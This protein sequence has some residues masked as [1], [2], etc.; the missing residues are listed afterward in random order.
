MDELNI[1]YCLPEIGEEE[2]AEVVDT[3]RSGW[4]T[5]GPKT[6]AFEE[7]I[8]AYT[9]AKYAVAVNSCTAALH[10]SLL[11]Y[12]IGRGDEVIT[13]PYTFAST[14]NVI[15]HSGARPVFADIQRDTF[16]I[17]P[18][19]INEAITPKTKAIIPVHF[20]G[21]PCDM[22]E[23]QEIADDHNLVVIEDA[24]HAIGAEYRGKKIG[25][26]S[27][28]TCFSFYATKNMT[29]GEGGAVTTDDQKIADKMRILRLHGISKD[30]WKRYSAQGSWYYEIEEC[31]WKYN[32]TDIQAALGI[33]QLRKL[34]G[35][36]ATRRKYAEMYSAALR[37]L[38]GVVTPVEKEGRKHV[39]HLYPVLVNEMNRGD[40][41]REMAEMGIG[42]SV[43]FIPLH[44]HPAYQKLFECMKGDCPNATWLYEHEVSLPLYPK[45]SLMDLESVISCINRVMYD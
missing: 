6:I 35:F 26:L 3:L 33:H 40:F 45:M 25:S 39:Y 11:A 34:D 29:T 27:D 2:I 42:C 30:A 36:V 31:G 24:A 41:I 9:G 16:N 7:Q 37:D 22:K 4:L 32:M 23:I 38:E 28:A 18:E 12:G 15:V 20:A 13:S 44:Q 43:H 17:D 21:Q 14:G 5:M 8:A 19:K 10:L 1:P